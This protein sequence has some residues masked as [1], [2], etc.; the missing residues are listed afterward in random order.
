MASSLVWLDMEAVAKVLAVWQVLV[1][2]SAEY[3]FV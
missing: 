2:G 1:L 3:F